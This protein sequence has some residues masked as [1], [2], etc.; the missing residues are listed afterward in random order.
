MDVWI[1]FNPNALPKKIPPRVE[2]NTVLVT[3][4]GTSPTIRVPI[5]LLL[6]ILRLEIF[7]YNSRNTRNAF[8]AKL[9]ILLY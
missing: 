2:G 3:N 6:H 9:V 4:K 7:I 1:Y 5:Q 8:Q